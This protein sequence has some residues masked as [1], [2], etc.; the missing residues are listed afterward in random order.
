MRAG[1]AMVC[2]C[3]VASGWGCGGTMSSPVATTVTP[4]APSPPRPPGP[5]V[6]IGALITVG[7]VVGASVERTDPVCFPNWDST[8]AC[9]SYRIVPPQNGTLEVTLTWDRPASGEDLMDLFIV[10]PSGIWIAAYDG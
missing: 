3:A 2:A 7:Q 6:G 10:A 1:V 4:V 9:K 8:G 5:S